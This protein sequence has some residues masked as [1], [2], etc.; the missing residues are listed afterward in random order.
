VRDLNAALG[1][2]LDQVSMGEAVADVPADAQI[3]ALGVE[4]PS[5]I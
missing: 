2:D 4:Y 1:H 5:Y 3:D